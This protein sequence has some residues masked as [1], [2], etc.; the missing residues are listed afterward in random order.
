MRPVG[1]ID[2][3]AEDVHAA[4]GGS[5]ER[6]E[7]TDQQGADDRPEQAADAPDDEHGQG[8]EGQV[9]IDV[10]GRDRARLVDEEGTCEPA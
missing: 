10:F 5:E 3:Q 7:T 9:Q 4:L 8:Q 2:L 6:V 1:E